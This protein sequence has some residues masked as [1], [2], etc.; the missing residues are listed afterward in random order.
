MLAR[1][2]KPVAALALA[3]ALIALIL[4]ALGAEPLAGIGI[5]VKGALSQTDHRRARLDNES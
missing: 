2:A 4:L 5:S 1:L 3:A